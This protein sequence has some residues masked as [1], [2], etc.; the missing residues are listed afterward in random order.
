M[1][2]SLNFV[3]FVPLGRRDPIGRVT[4]RHLGSF[5]RKNFLR[6]LRIGAVGC[7]RPQGN[8]CIP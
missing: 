8:S 1:E 2:E 7:V 5:L 3:I 6:A 4:G